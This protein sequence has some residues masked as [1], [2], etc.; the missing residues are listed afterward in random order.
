MSAEQVEVSW[1]Q[2]GA[3]AE[4]TVAMFMPYRPLS[5][6]VT[7]SC[8]AAGERG[9]TV[10]ST[11]P[12]GDQHG[13]RWGLSLANL[14]GTL[15]LTVDGQQVPLGTP[16]SAACT[17]TLHADGQQLVATLDGRELARRDA[18]VPQVVAFVTETSEVSAKAKADARFQTS[19]TP[20]KLGLMIACALGVAG[21]AVLAF[22]IWRGGPPRPK[23]R[24]GTDAAWSALAAVV[25]GGWGV[26]A[27]QTVDDGWFLG[28]HRNF[29]AAGYAGDYYMALNAAETPAVLL[30][31]LFAPLFE[32][33]WSPLMTR[34]PSLLAGFAIWLL[35][36]GI[37]RL[38][39]L[40]VP[41]WLLGAAF[42]VAW[43]PGGVGLR[44]EPFI[45]LCTA[46]AAYAALR[47]RVT[48]RP[49][50]LVLGGLATGLCLTITSTGFLAAIPVA[51]GLLHACR[52]RVP[53]RVTLVLATLAA[54][55]LAAP[56]AF[57][58]SGIGGFLDS[59]GSRYW[60]GASSTW[61][62]EFARY[63]TLLWPGISPEFLFEQHPFRRLPVLL[64]IA[65]L[66][67]VVVLRLRTRHGGVFT[68]PAGV[69]FA[70]LG[71]GYVA[72][73]FTPSKVV[74][75]FS[76][77]AAFT[78]LAIAIGLA[79]LPR[80]FAT[81]H[82]GWAVRGGALFAVL[83]LTS[84]TWYGTN[85]WFAYA[86]LGMPRPDEPLLDGWLAHPVVL[87]LAA[88][89]LALPFLRRR[90]DPAPAVVRLTGWSALTLATATV[91][92]M[93]V[94]TAGLLAKAALNQHQR[95]QFSGPA[96][97]AAGTCGPTAASGPV[98]V[99]WPIAFW[100]PCTRL[101]ALADGLLEPPV[102]AIAAP[103]AYRYA[104]DLTRRHAPHGG[105]FAPMGPVAT[106]TELPGDPALGTRYEVAYRYP[107]GRYTVT[108]TTTTHT[109][110]H[111]ETPYTD[112]DYLGRADP[113]TELHPGQKQE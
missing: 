72:L 55:A 103:P 58:D 46:A 25:I 16:P 76:A 107:T 89:A 86:A 73:I 64:G 59:A 65:I 39:P 112:P 30:H 43:M 106:Y 52:H 1:P 75:H 109:G 104:G 3:R 20:L 96:T 99:D 49:A 42:L 98:L 47:A 50:W 84:L 6:D 22:T 37:V 7:A 66:G 41:R 15:V 8:A 110:W 91:L 26:L 78:A 100:Y 97:I 5:L 2:Q 35:L 36:L 95:G 11:F 28:M 113:A 63:Q 40:H 90:P 32:L 80:A 12:P 31:H 9:R 54:A 81:E 18:L 10:F 69:P 34:V 101:P 53:H 102:S 44:P 105:A 61:Y 33:S 4:S 29:E 48:D 87:L 94:L 70:W 56:I 45:A 68:G 67:I 60:H 71:L 108:T 14:D 82:T 23:R 51:L 24:W 57:V 85:S 93:P 21:C 92:L 111:R 62:D 13:Q 38:L 17:Y 77:L 27:P 74:S 79:A 88:A 83:L 19:P